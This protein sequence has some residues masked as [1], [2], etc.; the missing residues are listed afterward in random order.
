MGS[1][2]SRKNATFPFETAFS[3]ASSSFRPRSM[4]LNWRA[5][6]PRNVGTRLKATAS[7]TGGGEEDEDFEEFTPPLAASCAANKRAQ[8]SSSL[9]S[10]DIHRMT[11]PPLGAAL[12][13]SESWRARAGL[14]LSSTL[15]FGSA[16]PAPPPAAAFRSSSSDDEEAPSDSD[17]SG[18]ALRFPLDDGADFGAMMS[19]LGVEGE[20]EGTSQGEER[21]TGFDGLGD[22]DDDDDDLA[23]AA[24][25]TIDRCC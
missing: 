19:S 5:P 6:A 24:T 10:R 15:R 18:L 16:A 20:G 3:F 14:T 22:D 23:A 7:G 9:W 21:E 12:F 2:S 8:L 4:K 25:T 17:D 13:S 11:G 1:P